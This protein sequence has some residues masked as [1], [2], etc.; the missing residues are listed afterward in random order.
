MKLTD[1]INE[2]GYISER[3]ELIFE[4]LCITNILKFDPQKYHTV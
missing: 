3:G 1:Y 4:N 2:H